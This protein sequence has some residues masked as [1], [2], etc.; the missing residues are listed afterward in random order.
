MDIA[1][2]TAHKQAQCSIQHVQTKLPEAKC[3]QQEP[4]N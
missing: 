2:Q 3:K 1:G 4:E